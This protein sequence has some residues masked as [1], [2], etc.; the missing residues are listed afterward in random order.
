MKEKAIGNTVVLRLEI[1]EDIV[2]S[3]KDVCTRRRT[4]A[5]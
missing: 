5:A 2:K 3:I 4:L 1:G